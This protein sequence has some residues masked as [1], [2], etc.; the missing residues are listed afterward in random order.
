MKVLQITIS[1]C[2]VLAS[3]FIMCQKGISFGGL[4]PFFFFG[5]CL[6]IFIFEEQMNSWASRF[7]QKRLEAKYCQ[8]KQ[9]HLLFPKGYYFKAGFLKDKNILPYKNIDEIRINTKP[10]T[11]KINQN[12]I[13]FLKGVNKEA[14][15]AFAIQH[16]IPLLSP[17]DNWQLIADVIMALEWEAEERIGSIKQLEKVGISE[18][19]VM[20]LRKLFSTPLYSDL[21]YPLGWIYYGHCDVLEQMYR[22]KEDKY[23]YTMEIALSV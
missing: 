9:D 13:I 23:W 4:F 5:L 7:H 12:E 22:M 3:I 21:H 19:D 20:G 15:E 16:K 6:L 8:V 2:F 11:A 18:Q 14:L 10:I 1:A 17:M